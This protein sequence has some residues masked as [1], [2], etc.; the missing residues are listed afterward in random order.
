MLRAKSL[1]DQAG[2][3]ERKIALSFAQ[4]TG[5]IE[6]LWYTNAD[7]V[8]DGEVS[9]GG[10]RADR[11]EKPEIGVMRGF[12][13]FAKQA[14]PYFVSPETPEVTIVTSQAAQF[15]Q[16]QNEQLRVQ[17]RAV[18]ALS[19]YARVTGTMIA[20]N[21][22]AK[23]GHPKLVILPS[24]QALGEDTW[25]ALLAYV[26][27]G[28][29]LLITGPVNRDTYWHAIDRLADA[30]MQ[31]TVEPLTWR[32]STI[33]ATNQ[34]I[35]MS[36]SQG[37]QR[38]LEA[39][40]FENNARFQ[41]QTFGQGRIFWSSDPVEPAEEPG[42]AGQL[43]SF[44]LKQVG[45]TTLFESDPGLSPGVLIYPTILKDAVLY[46]FA[47]SDAQDAKDRHQ[48]QGHR[49]AHRVHA[50]RRTRI[51]RV[52]EKEGRVGNRAIPRPTD[53]RP[54]KHGRTSHKIIEAN[55]PDPIMAAENYRMSA[56]SRREFLA[57]L[58]AA[59]MSGDA[60]AQG[61]PPSSTPGAPP[62]FGTAGAVGPEVTA[63][64]FTDAEKLV[65]VSLT[66]GERA[67]A[68]GNWRNAMAPVYERRTGPRRVE[69]P[70]TV[71]PFSTVH[72]ILPGE[73]QSPSQDR[74]IRSTTD[75]GP[76]PANDRDIA[77]APVA[78]LSKWIE[79]RQLSSERL[80]RIDLD[81][82]GRFN[83]RLNCIITLTADHAIEQAIDA[84][85]EITEGN[86]R[87]PLH[88]IPWGAK[89]LLDTAGI[90]TTYGAEPFRSRVPATD[91]TVT[92]RLNKAGAVLIAKLSMGAL[93][94]NDIW[95]GGQTMNPWL[96]EEGASGS[97]ACPGAAT[98]AGLVGFAI[99]SE[100]LG[101]ITSPSMR[102]GVTGL[103]PTFGRVPRTGAMALCWS[104]DKLGPMA[105]S[106]E[107]TMLVLH[108]ISG[109]DNIDLSCVPSHLDFDATA[110]VDGLRVGYVPAW[111]KAAS[112]VDR[113]ALD[114]AR[115]LGMVPVEI[116]L[117][118]WPY[119]S[120]DLILFAEAAAAFEELTL[121]RKVNQ[122]K[123]QTPDAW[124]N[125]F[126]QSRFLSA[127][128]LVQTDRFRRMVAQQMAQVMAVSIFCLSLLRD[129]M[130]TITN[131]TGHPSLTLRAGF[132]EV[133][134]ARSDWAP[135]PHHPL[136][137][138]SPPRRVPY[139]VTLIG[140][141]FDEGTIAR[142]GIALERAFH[143]SLEKPPGF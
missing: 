17:Q 129:E 132:V 1:E 101:S 85:N 28:G 67:Q 74:F 4:G 137:K 98:A 76:L 30:N 128:D 54:A 55:H 82:I 39:I 6:W 22:I 51:R 53:C 72:S 36:F 45:V 105:R 46:L 9:L 93:A 32:T 84:D 12:A 113:A 102:C 5:A 108:A 7:M 124:P 24:P 47:S 107:D 16:M 2:L 64:T 10:V 33:H 130:L 109:P 44:V 90:A 89:D 111:M 91:A 71:Q 73:T 42:A 21:E 48:G 118:D 60:L 26:K 77:Y 136:P 96:T 97:S 18:Q 92:E 56:A 112:D 35:P 122:L 141:L 20:E 135:D 116:S 66:P 70:G 95:F 65:Q 79:R 99:G 94:L 69:I 62:A 13:A 119:D 34:P 134:E 133:T 58:A 117:P 106:V 3:F 14:S 121:S 68:A 52:V 87:G 142:A 125:T 25:Q 50:A 31:G 40:H 27:G 100:T 143:V 139:G 114:T 131:F 37:D 86:Y 115:Q 104:L 61:P 11:T 19:Y 83:Q 38:A 29:N 120:L 103:R 126:R 23:L 78:H 75:P 49:S 127:V 80:T 140:R 88:G 41:Q 8:E 59:A 43:Y 15:S 123:T 63:A 138:F 57:L 81:R 110:P